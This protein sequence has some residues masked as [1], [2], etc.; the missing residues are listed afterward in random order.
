MKW[1]GVFFRYTSAAASKALRAVR[2]GRKS[3]SGTL[4]PS[5]RIALH[6]IGSLLIMEAGSL[7]SWINDDAAGLHQLVPSRMAASLFMP[8]EVETQRHFLRD[9][10]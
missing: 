4:R 10:P 7:I 3:A 5:E 2:G 9:A 1:S 6:I 8:P